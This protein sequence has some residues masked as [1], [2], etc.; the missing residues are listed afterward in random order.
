MDI[1]VSGASG[2]IGTV[3]ISYLQSKGHTVRK[4]VRK[5]TADGKDE[6]V[7]NPKENKLDPSALEGADAIINLSG[8]NVAAERWTPEFKERIRNSRIQST[9]LIVDTINKLKPSPPVLLNA[10][11]TGYYGNRGEEWLTEASVSGSG[12]L[13]K[14]C[15]DWENE[16][17]R[18]QQA[19]V[20]VALLRFGMILS[21]KGGALKKMLMPFKLGLGGPIGSGE[22]YISWIALDDA[23]KAIGFILDNAGLSGPINIVSAEPVTNLKFTEALGDALH[24]PTVLRMPAFMARLGF[25]E[26]VDELLLASERVK[27]EKLIQSG[28]EFQFPTIQDALAAIK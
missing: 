20:R 6:I 23:A 11:A 10:S 2:F 18:A 1:V 14:A 16:A 26:I 19:G 5:N 27:P 12:F 24:R 3:L 21:C 25:G 8:E 13:A 28:F 7:W 22:Q 4:L 15:V 17:L 9:R